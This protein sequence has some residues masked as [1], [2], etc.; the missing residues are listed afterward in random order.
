ML[1]SRQRARLRAL[2]STM[3]PVVHVGKDGLAPG[4]VRQTDEAL[5]AR[6]LI[7]GTVQQNSDID[8]REACRALA[9]ETG[10][11]PVAAMGRKFV[12]YRRNGDL[13]AIDID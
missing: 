10:A 3:E 2:A 9:E 4:V 11:E 12:L 5:A 13:P 8:A 7:K 1:N 6:Q